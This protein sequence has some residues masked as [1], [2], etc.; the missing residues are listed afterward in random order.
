[1]A[2][3]GTSRL[4]QSPREGRA[5]PLQIPFAPGA[6]FMPARLP[7]IV[8]NGLDRSGH[9]LVAASSA[10]GIN[11]SPTNTLY[12]G[13]GYLPPIASLV[14]GRWPSEAR[15][16]GLRKGYMP[17]I[18]G[19]LFKRNPPISAFAPFDKGAFFTPGAKFVPAR[20]PC[21]L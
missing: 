2:L 19:S 8:G 17:L 6:K 9:V 5:P 18:N 15:S 13:H 12:A 20:Q 4:P 10:G 21:A 14:K 16:E 1:M 11:P 7:C 3:P